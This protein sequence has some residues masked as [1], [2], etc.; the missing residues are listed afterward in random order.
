MNATMGCERVLEAMKLTFI[1]IK[2]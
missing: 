1:S 2:K